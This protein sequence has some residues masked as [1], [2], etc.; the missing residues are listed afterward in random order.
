VILID[1]VDISRS[2]LISETGCSEAAASHI[3]MQVLCGLYCIHQHQL[4]HRD[5]KPDNLLVSESGLGTVALARFSA[6]VVTT[7]TLYATTT[8]TTT[9]TTTAAAAAAPS[10]Q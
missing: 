3:M 5:I 10:I 1:S 2:D 7:L 9:A 4:I 6:T 8:T